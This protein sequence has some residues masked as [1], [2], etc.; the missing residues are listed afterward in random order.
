MLAV[1]EK[2]KRPFYNF[3]MPAPPTTITIPV[4]AIATAFEERL[5]LSMKV[6]ISADGTIERQLFTREALP[7]LRFDEYEWARFKKMIA[8]SEEIA[9]RGATVKI[10]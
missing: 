7:L 5:Q 1:V 2:S 6:E 9:E 8:E 10:G 4:N 3:S